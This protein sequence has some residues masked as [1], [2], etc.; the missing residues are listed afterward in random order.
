VPAPAPQAGRLHRCGGGIAVPLPALTGPLRPATMARSRPRISAH[1]RSFL[2]CRRRRHGRGSGRPIWRK[3]PRERACSGHTPPRSHHRFGVPHEAGPL[4][5]TRFPFPNPQIPCSTHRQ[6]QRLSLI[7]SLIHVDAPR[8]TR[9][10]Q[11]LLS[12]QR[13]HHGPPCTGLIPEKRKVGGSIPLLTT[14]LTSRNA[15]VRLS[16]LRRYPCWPGA[17]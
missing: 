17:W 5:S 2:P 14:T 7:R 12:R 15:L 4:A 10:E 1:Q 13:N 9:V 16:G 3:F 11:G 6:R 8:S